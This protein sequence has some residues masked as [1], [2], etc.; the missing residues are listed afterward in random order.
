ML[1]YLKYLFV[2]TIAALTI[3]AGIN[4]FVDPASVYRP[5]KSS[6]KEFAKALVKSEYG[7]WWI[8]NTPTD[9]DIKTA[10]VSTSNNNV[11]C[12]V[13]GSSRVM[14]I[15]SA[16]SISSLHEQCASILNLGVSGGSIEA[17]YILS[18]LA[19][20]NLHPRKIVFGIDPWTFAFK[21]DPRWYNYAND[22]QLAKESILGHHNQL[23][24]ENTNT[25]SGKVM[26]L[27]SL[28]YTS[29]SINKLLSDFQNHSNHDV[30]STAPKL[31][32]RLGGENPILFRDGS[33]LSSSNSFQSQKKNF[34]PLGGDPYG[35]D[36]AINDLSAVEAYKSLLR[37]VKKQ[38]VEPILLMTP[39]HQ[40]VLLK[41][42]SLNVRA[43]DTIEPIIK[44]IGNEFGLIVIGSYHP[45]KAGCLS[46][47]F[48]DFMHAT[49]DCLAKLH[50]Q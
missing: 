28:L 27:F 10:L 43:I 12:V 25:V 5:N 31:D 33:L 16:R 6:A 8:E 23:S 41:P 7:L 29:K 11:D 40:N 38:G 1:K 24:S 44:Q 32:E 47:E 50:K 39:Y 18:Y 34:I 9:W 13:I 17:H 42:D 22:Y 15:G 3:V 36:G 4:Y 35:T 49:P 2:T 14:Q 20:K 48:F 26:N 21:K 19:L 46:T 45:E 37:W 30:I